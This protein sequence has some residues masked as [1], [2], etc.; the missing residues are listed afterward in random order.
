[1]LWSDAS[2]E[3]ERSIAETLAAFG[4]FGGHLV[5]DDA[6]E[7]AGLAALAAAIDRWRAALAR[8]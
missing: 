7:A 2:L 4:G 5:I 6:S 3:T 8:R 1:L